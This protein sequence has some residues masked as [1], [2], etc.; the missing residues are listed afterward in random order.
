MT[1]PRHSRGSETAKILPAFQLTANYSV[2]HIPGWQ[3]KPAAVTWFGKRENFAGFSVDRQPCRDTHQ[4]SCSYDELLLTRDALSMH[5]RWVYNAL[6]M[7][8]RFDYYY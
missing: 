2:I 8:S 4:S 7:H 6:P 5:F 3:T 1:N